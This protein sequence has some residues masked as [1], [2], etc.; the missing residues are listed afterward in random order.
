MESARTYGNQAIFG[1]HLMLC[2]LLEDFNFDEA[3]DFKFKVWASLPGL[4]LKL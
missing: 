4:K 1:S 2:H 3:L